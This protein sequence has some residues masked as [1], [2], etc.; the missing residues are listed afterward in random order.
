MLI[1]G[2]KKENEFAFTK[3]YS[4]PHSN[5]DVLPCVAVSPCPSVLIKSLDSIM[6]DETC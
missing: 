1:N 2:V 6:R 3:L 5:Q 4:L